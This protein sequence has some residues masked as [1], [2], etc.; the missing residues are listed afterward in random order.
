LS[1]AEG[2]EPW[3]NL[4]GYS[5]TALVKIVDR[6]TS[7]VAGISSELQ[8][9]ALR[10][11]SQAEAILQEVYEQGRADQAKLELQGRDRFLESVPRDLQDA[12]QKLLEMT[13]RFEERDAELLAHMQT[14]HP[15]RYRDIEKILQRESK[16]KEI[17]EALV[18]R[19]W[20]AVCGEAQY[21][22]L[23]DEDCDDCPVEDWDDVKFLRAMGFKRP[24]AGT[25]GC[26][27]GE[28]GFTG[29]SE[30]GET[31]DTGE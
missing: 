2:R 16:I 1:E 19:L 26:P 7:H 12:R 8:A 9:T 14:D 15:E 18:S 23:C 31:G 5:S 3:E 24:A 29:P 28:F 11:K 27:V 10:I 4:S 25:A 6:L 22:E 21:M 17:N 30:C 20:T 13:R